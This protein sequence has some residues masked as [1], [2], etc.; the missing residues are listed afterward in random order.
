MSLSEHLIRYQLLI[1]I[2]VICGE[3]ISYYNRVSIKYANAFVYNEDISLRQKY[4]SPVRIISLVCQNMYPSKRKHRLSKEIPFDIPF[5]RSQISSGLIMTT[6]MSLQS[7]L[8]TTK[9]TSLERVVLNANGNLQHIFSAFYDSPVFVNVVHCKSRDKLNPFY[10]VY[11]RKSQLSVCNQVFCTAKTIFVVKSLKYASLI[12]S[13]EIG[14]GQLFRY[15]NVSPSFTLID[16]GKTFENRLWRLY[17]LRCD[18][19]I[20]IIQEKF[21]ID[22]W[23]FIP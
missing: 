19:L 13:K 5:S 21:A 20:C 11:D 17:V 7:L 14:I 1:L 8:N 15:L 3:I 10:E 18:G 6:S 12:Q 4:L 2:T 16:G 9:L 23:K 22:L